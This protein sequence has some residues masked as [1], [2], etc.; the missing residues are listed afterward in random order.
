M[1]ADASAAVGET[2]GDRYRVVRPLGEGGMSTVYLA[3]HRMTGRTV[4]IKLVPEA[5]PVMRERVLREA[6]SMGRLQHPNVVGVLDM[7]EWGGSVFLVMEY[8]HGRNLREY[9]GRRR[10]S[11]AEAVDL[12]LPACSGVAAAHQASILHRDLKPENL[13][14]CTDHG[15]EAFDTKVLDFGVAKHLGEGAGHSTL[16]DSGSLVGTPKY[17]APEQIGDDSVLDERTDVYAL[18]LI[19]Y[20][21]LAG[22]LPYET[23][24][25]RNIVLEILKGQLRPLKDRAPDI[26][27]GLSDVVMRALSAD[28][29]GRHASVAELAHALEPWAGNAKFVPPRDVHTRRP[30][31]ESMRPPPQ[32]EETL[33]EGSVETV[34]SPDSPLHNPLRAPP[35]PD[36][37]DPIATSNDEPAAAPQGNRA[38]M[39]VAVAALL[40]VIVAAWAL[41]GSEPPPTETTQPDHAA[42]APAPPP[43]AS[44]PA[45]AVPAPAEARPE[46]AVSPEHAAQA[47][48]EEPQAEPQELAAPAAQE[49]TEPAREPAAAERKP[50]R[51]RKRPGPAPEPEAEPTS[52]PPTDNRDPWATKPSN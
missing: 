15:G 47:V 34:V 20:E 30:T 45:P 48:A 27:A 29:T 23:T 11:P 32:A 2:I 52:Y 50:G 37:P 31:A 16:T 9:L 22:T 44:E 28:P 26:P 5:D 39:G 13:F 25:L 43:S 6:R 19:L 49:P 12:M 4:A 14:V 1:G 33:T 38:W 24:G 8:V 46:E 10:A 42:P 18:G 36:L 7:G 35:V 41:L 17:M 21:M 51:A 40:A 3:R